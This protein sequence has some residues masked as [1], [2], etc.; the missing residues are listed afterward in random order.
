MK[1]ADYARAGDIAPVTIELPEG[2]LPQFAFSIEP[3]LRKLGM[4]SKLDKGFELDILKLY[5]PLGAV[6]LYQSFEVCREG[7]PITVDQAKVGKSYN[8]K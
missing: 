1:E 5:S 7:E 2:P 6:A 3:Q 4:P 8:F